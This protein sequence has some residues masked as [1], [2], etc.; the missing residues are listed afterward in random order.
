MDL[1]RPVWHLPV[2]VTISDQAP[3]SIS[4][5]LG[6]WGAALLATAMLAALQMS[7][8]GLY[9]LDSY[10]HARAT[11]DLAVH[12]V[13]TK[14]PQAAFSTWAEVY[15]DKDF[16]FHAIL[17][18][19]ISHDSLVQGGK[20]GV[21]VFDL[22]LFLSVAFAVRSL[23]MRFG[24]VWVLLL[25]GASAYYVTRLVSLRPHIFGL[26]FVAVEIALVARDRWK[27]LFVVS[28]LHV[29][30]HSSFPIVAALYG[31][32]L[33]VA[34][35]Q[36]ETWPIRSGVAIVAGFVVASLAHPY[37]PN[38]LDI[39]YA[40]VFR[41]AGHLWGGAAEIPTA[42]FGSELRPMGMP[43]FLL[44]AP[45]W[46]PAALG[47]VAMVFA[48]RGRGWSTRDLFLLFATL[49]FTALAFASRRFLDMFVLSAVLLAGGLWTTLSA[50]RSLREL[51]VSKPVLA[52]GSSVAVAACLVWGLTVAWTDLPES[53][54]NQSYADIFRPT[55]AQLD[56]FADPQ[57]V[58][59]HP[60]WREFSFLYAFRPNGRYISGLDPMFLHAKSPDLF[61]KS[62]RLSRGF[63]KQPHLVLA[64]DFGAR[65]VFVT[66]EKRFTA[67]RR[68]LA[69]TPGI[70][71]VFEGPGAEIW[72][73]APLE[74]PT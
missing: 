4:E 38:N 32:R 49:A 60:T 2:D 13:Q 42:A 18:P 61:K 74:P 17:T 51:I 70:D 26:A 36:R 72:A 34:L 9:D 53:F 59:Y 16:L 73:V 66:T 33:L 57:D 47:L 8:P 29:W 58:V 62:W 55:V 67:F 63:S 43:T 48:R 12:G 65:W 1:R 15:S 35:L 69:R 5:R 10:F 64:R 71:R 46:V 28:A 52:G 14:F 50:D 31:I 54:A 6:T 37:F 40:V 39:A 56:F 68:L 7:F 44:A 27:A 20:W 19:L 45:G 23:R 21:I 41:L 25:V 22:L 24:F 3:A 11:T 30:A